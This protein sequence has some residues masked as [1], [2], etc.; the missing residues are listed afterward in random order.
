MMLNKTVFLKNGFIL[1]LAFPFFLNADMARADWFVDGSAEFLF[2]DNLNR[3]QLDSDIRSDTSLQ[4]MMAGGY[5]SQVADYT[6]VTVSGAFNLAH[7]EDYSDLNNVALN[8]ALSFS[9][10]F[11]IGE[12]VP[13]LNGLISISEHYYEYAIRDVEVR[14]ADIFLSKRFSDVLELSI[15]INHE[16][17]RSDHY[18]SFDTNS[19]SSYLSGYLDINSRDWLSFS[20]TSRSGE[21]SS[22]TSQSP[23]ILAA[24]TASDRDKTFE[25]GSQIIAY[26]LDAETD[27][28]SIDWNRALTASSTFYVGLEKQDSKAVAGFNY[29]VNLFRV[30]LINSW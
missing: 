21:I 2:N 15:G 11:G 22:S 6:S 29:D 1:L 9:H 27:V 23:L 4:L 10:K 5:F 16:D 14:Q 8:L 28:Y 19:F 24:S 20:Y 30:G 26:R 12:R 18:F 7:Y 17:R 25:K 3:A 13:R